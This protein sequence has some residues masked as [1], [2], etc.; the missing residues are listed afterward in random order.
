MHR[1]WPN[2]HGFALWREPALLAQ[3]LLGPSDPRQAVTP[4]QFEAY[5]VEQW[6]ESFAREKHWTDQLVIDVARERE[7]A[8]LR[9]VWRRLGANR[10][11][12]ER[13]RC[14]GGG[15]NVRW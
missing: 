10:G 4:V 5:L 15:R 6:E 12:A 7:R 9:A 3:N 13:S 8:R 2:E 14:E 11:D 1:Q